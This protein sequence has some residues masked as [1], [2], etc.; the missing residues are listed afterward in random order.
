MSWYLF[1][2]IWSAIVI[3]FEWHPAFF[4]LSAL[5]FGIGW[6]NEKTG[7]RRV[8]MLLLAFFFFFRLYQYTNEVHQSSFREG[9]SVEG[10]LEVSPNQ[11]KVNGDLMTGT[12]E[13]KVHGKAEKVFFR[14]TLNTKE[15]KERWLSLSHVVEVAIQGQFETI[16][17]N[18]NKGNFDAYHYY[19]SLGVKSGLHIQ[20]LETSVREKKS[21]RAFFENVRTWII[22][23]IRGQKDSKVKQ[24]AQALLLADRQ[25]FDEEV[26]QQYKELGILHLLAISGLHI[27]LMVSCI[28]KLLWRLGLTRE[29]TGW[30]L[31]FLVMLYGIVIGWTIS[32]T[33][34]IGMVVLSI[35]AKQWMGR[36]QNLQGWCLMWMTVLS[37]LIYPALLFNIAFQLSYLLT[38]LIIFFSIWQKRVLPDSRL[39]RQIVPAVVSFVALPFICRYFFYFNLFSIL[40][41]IAFSWLFSFILFPMLGTYLIGVFTGATFLVSVVTSIGGILLDGLSILLSFC[42]QVPFTKFILGIWDIW[43]WLTY[44]GLIAIVCLIFE[45]RKM[46]AKKGV[47]LFGVLLC[48]L[49]EVPY[50]FGVELILVDVGQGDSILWLLPGWNQATLVDT[51]GL[52]TFQKKDEWQHRKKRSQGETTVVPALEAEGLSE[53]SQVMLSHGDEDHV[54]NLEVIAKHLSIRNIIIAKGMEKIERMQKIKKSYPKIKWK[55]V[56]AGDAWNWNESRW[57]VLSPVHESNAENED[58][59]LAL[60]TVSK[61]SVLLT[62]DA[63]THVEEEVLSRYPKLHFTILKAGHH[64]SKTSSG[65]AL[66]Q[67]AKPALTLISCGKNNRYGH[68]SP[69]TLQ[70]LLKIQSTVFRTDQDG[71]IRV[72]FK[73]R[74]M[75]ILTELSNRKVLLKQ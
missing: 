23:T 33:R 14:T 35:L 31:L 43:E 54:G 67:Q 25:D 1:S 75:F 64:G 71:Q 60:V 13:L 66:L 61:Q 30:V 68:P 58:S 41:T 62:G 46:T 6:K 55:L 2:L 57:E 9:D 63:S 18:R 40:L 5:W 24:Y 3:V 8:G 36:I 39:A 11:L 45:K 47:L 70:R 21:F 34:A 44:W 32:G 17:K 27:S 26:W 22:K 74:G 4:V 50:H 28:E 38:A 20:K 72:Q 48:L 51:G 10:I 49:V 56:S 19:L 15:E 53:L 73:R 29:K 7:Y 69:D 59:I 42:Q 52:P 16:E 37:I 65:Q 12:G